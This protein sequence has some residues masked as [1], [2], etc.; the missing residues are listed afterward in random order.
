V[1]GCRA[2]ALI[3][4]T[5]R[6]LHEAAE[7]RVERRQQPAASTRMTAAQE[8]RDR[9][10]VGG[11]GTS[12]RRRSGRVGGAVVT[13][14]QH[15]CRRHGSRADGVK[16]HAAT[17]RKHCHRLAGRLHA[18]KGTVQLGVLMVSVL[19]WRLERRR[20]LLLVME[21][22]LL[23]LEMVVQLVLLLLVLLKIWVLVLVM[24][25]LLMLLLLLLVLILLMSD[26]LGVIVGQGVRGIMRHVEGVL[27]E[28]AAG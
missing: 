4:T 22:R 14:M 2:A 3:A 15:V 21:V 24:G 28:Q 6:E 10:D 27:Q 9:A 7:R 20:A 26:P 1:P 23:V 13:V 8:E 11:V 17:A 12:S 19:E 16:V 25:L 5:A 18:G